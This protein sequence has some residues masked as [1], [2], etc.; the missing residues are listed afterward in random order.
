MNTS[1]F[2]GA[3]S[4]QA[5]AQ[6]AN[7][8]NEA[9]NLLWTGGW[10]STFRLL[11]LVLIRKRPV[12]PFYVVS[13]VRKSSELE[14]STMD[15]I[16]NLLYE[17]HPESRPLLL[18]A[19]YKKVEEIKTDDAITQQYKRLAASQ[20]LGNQYDFLARFA[21]EA[22]IDALELSIH[23]DD[24][25]QKF[26]QAYVVKEGDNYRLQDNPSY[27]DLK[28]FK[29]FRF[30][31]LELTKLDMERIAAKHNFLDLLNETVF[32]H[33]PL[34]NGTPCGHCNPCRYTIAE[35]LKRRVPFA[36]RLR[37]NVIQAIKPPVKYALRL[38]RIKY[39]KPA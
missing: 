30:P 18:P 19:V 35:G 38:L 26:L 9:A 2:A 27:E 24:H 8:G 28:L 17:K 16:R 31:I 6:D 21:D 20:H 32:C 10:D 23:K 22:G 36:R 34:K 39:H 3:Y 11:D 29:H 13:P 33:T 4:E 7:N 15:K 1:T 14:I 5:R 12:Q 37:Y 25:A